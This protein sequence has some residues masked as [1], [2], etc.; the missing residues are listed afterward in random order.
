M[1]RVAGQ[2]GRRPE[3]PGGKPRPTPSTARPAAAAPPSVAPT[4]PAKVPVAHAE[5][6][7]TEAPETTTPPEEREVPRSNGNGARAKT[8]PPSLAAP[9]SAA[10]AAPTRRVHKTP[11]RSAGEQPRLARAVD[12]ARGV[13]TPAAREDAPPPRAPAEP[14]APVVRP[15]EPGDIEPELAAV[16]VLVEA[17]GETDDDAERDDADESSPTSYRGLIEWGVVILGAFLVAVLLKTFVFQAFYIPSTSM[18]PTLH[19]HDRVLV[20]KLS[21][22]L[23]GIHRGDLVVFERPDDDDGVGVDDLIKRVIGMPGDTVEVRDS[24]VLIDGDPLDEPYLPEGLDYPDMAPVVVPA[25][26]IFVMGDNRPDSRDSRVFGP[27]PQEDI[28]GRAFFRIW[29]LTRLGFL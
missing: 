19:V 21:D 10:P 28:V 4:P 11:T 27:I 18:M 16:G 8:L 17:D 6:E 20:N 3:A 25:G 5:P 24:T 1:S 12:E 26:E 2:R 14:S 7:A 22:D 9:A 29:P 23:D 15:E 13:S